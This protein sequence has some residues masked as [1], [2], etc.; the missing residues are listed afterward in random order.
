VLATHC[1]YATYRLW[2]ERRMQR[3]SLIRI[4]FALGLYA[5]SFG[6]VGCTDEGVGDP[7]VPEAIPCQAD[8]TGCGYKLTESYLEAS[9]VQCRSRLCLVYKLD[10][11][12]GGTLVSDPRNL[13]EGKNPVD[14]CVTNEALSNSVYCTC[15]CGSGG[16]KT[17]QELCDCTDG[18]EC[19]QV[20]TLGGDG[21]VGDYCVRKGAPE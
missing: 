3:S 20:L 14:G 7:C 1:L 9:S 15:R 5:L 17:K 16:A 11:D 19:R 21:I 12:T 6:A 8:G 4:A 13:C 2:K 18:F 10:N